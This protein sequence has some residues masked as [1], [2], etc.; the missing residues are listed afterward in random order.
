MNLSPLLIAC[1]I[2][3]LVPRLCTAST[4]V[5]VTS[6]PLDYH[7]IPNCIEV[8][9]NPEELLYKLTDSITITIRNTCTYDIRATLELQSYHGPRKGWRRI[10]D[11]LQ[12][13]W[14]EPTGKPTSP[15][16]QYQ[17]IPQATS[18]SRRV[19]RFLLL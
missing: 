19:R 1:A 16:S 5:S 6:R 17:I 7:L 12:E 3:W 15:E 2:L 14:A 8:T 13:Y 18:H 11:D 4:D 9:L 10:I